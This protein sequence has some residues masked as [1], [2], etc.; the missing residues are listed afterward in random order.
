MKRALVVIDVQNEY[1]TGGLPIGYPDPNWSLT[2]IA[3]AMDAAAQEGVPVVVVQ[4]VAPEGSPIFARGSHGCALPE[5]VA[6]RPYDHLV[7]KTLPSS[8]TGTD[9]ADWLA[10]H[11]IDTLSITGYMTQTCIEST[12][13]EA[14]HRGYGVEVL[15]DATGALPMSNRIGTLTAEQIHQT[16]LVVLQAFFASV[17]TT[18]QWVD[19][20]RHKTP[21]GGPDFAGAVEAARAAGNRP[22]STS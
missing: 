1:L 5:A 6:S 7:E 3:A 11:D 12:S 14:V 15:S 2:N 8:F 21:L 17:V 16:V 9:L 20:V 18:A 22:G 19:A 10:R 4:H 13:R